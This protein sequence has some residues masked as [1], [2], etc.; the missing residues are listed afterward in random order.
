MDFATVAYLNNANEKNVI[1]LFT[2]HFENLKLISNKLF[3]EM[4]SL[5]LYLWSVKSVHALIDLR[6]HLYY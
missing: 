2:A 4:G 1:V 5:L 6:D 3:W